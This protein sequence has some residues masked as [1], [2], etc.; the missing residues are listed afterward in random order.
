MKRVEGRVQEL[1]RPPDV[2]QIIP[3][4]TEHNA[5]VLTLVNYNP[6]ASYCTRPGR[7]A[8][9]IA[10]R[11]LCLVPCICNQSADTYSFARTLTSV[12]SIRYVSEYI[13]MT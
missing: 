3:N 13:P 4:S 2:S 6:P 7:K 10:Q 5:V 12:L 11:T 1:I 9:F 8:I